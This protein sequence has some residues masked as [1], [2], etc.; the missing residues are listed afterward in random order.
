MTFICF[1]NLDDLRIKNL[2]ETVKGQQMVLY[3]QWKTIQQLNDRLETQ[4]NI[5]KRLVDG[6]SSVQENKDSKSIGTPDDIMDSGLSRTDKKDALRELNEPTKEA[7][8][9]SNQQRILNYLAQKDSHETST[10]GANWTSTNDGRIDSHDT[11]DADENNR[12][13]IIKYFYKS[14]IKSVQELFVHCNLAILHFM[15]R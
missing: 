10:R 12:G 11:L 4:N 8:F 13:T 2:E 3:D 7:S 9:F 14:H 1:F 15:S 5:I 6:Y